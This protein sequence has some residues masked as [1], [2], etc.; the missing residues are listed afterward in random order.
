MSAR[1]DETVTPEK[2]PASKS[3]TKL[4]LLSFSNT[5]ID[6]KER[7]LHRMVHKV[8]MKVRKHYYNFFVVLENLKKNNITLYSPKKDR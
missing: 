6:P 7:L 4:D 8:S 3:L 2:R 5:K 1:K